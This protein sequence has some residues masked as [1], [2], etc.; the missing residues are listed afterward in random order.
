MRQTILGFELNT[1]GQRWRTFL[2]KT[3]RKLF[4]QFRLQAHLAS[5]FGRSVKIPVLGKM[6][7]MDLRD[8]AL[9]STLY[10]NGV[11]E[12]EETSFVGKTL[13]PGMVFVDVGAN[14]GYYTVIASELVGRSGQVFAFEPD[15]GNFAF[16]QKNIDANNCAN[17]VASQKAVAAATQRLR[18][19]RSEDNFGDHRIYEPKDETLHRQGKTRLAIDIDA[20]SLDDYFALNP[21]HVDFLKM[22]IQGAE[23]EAFIGMRKLL[24]QNPDITILTE[25]WPKGLGEAGVSPQVFLDEVRS[26]GFTIYLLD[27]GRSHE[28]SNSEILGGL[29]DEAYLSL[30]FSRRNFGSEG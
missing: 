29:S 1:R 28:V 10:A 27:H 11:W 3:I 9:S 24:G 5:L 14:I 18:L 8:G 20:I 23:Y 21:T 16:L 17:V 12:P 19:Y 15:P 13:H 22:D 25:F 26:S 2:G 4:P 7:N 6:L 30:V